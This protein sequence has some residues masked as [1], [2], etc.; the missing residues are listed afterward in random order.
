LIAS[1]K[2]DPE[3][4]PTQRSDEMASEFPGC[5]ASVHNQNP[6]AVVCSDQ[7]CDKF[8]ESDTFH[9]KCADFGK[10]NTLYPISTAECFDQNTGAT[11]E[12]TFVQTKFGLLPNCTPPLLT[13]TCFCCCSCLAFGTPIATPD[14]A[15]AIELFNI[16]DSVSVGSWDKSKL[17]WAN[18]LVQFSS[19]TDPGSINTMIFIQFG[20]GRKI[21]AT[22]DNLFLMSDGKL[23]RADR[24]V[25]GKDQI[26]TADGSALGVSAVLSGQWTKGLHHIATGLEFTG[27]LDGHLIN[28]NGIVTGDYCLQINQHE[29]I[30]RGLMDDPADTPALGSSK[31]AEMHGHLQTGRTFAKGSGEVNVPAG[32]KPF[33]LIDN[34][35][36]PD[37]AAKLFTDAQAQ[38]IVDNHDSTFRAV[39]D[40]S[41]FESM[42]YLIRLFKGFYPDINI[43]IDKTNPQFNTFAFEMY[44]KKHLVISGEILRM[45]GLFQE[46]YQFILAQ[47]IARLLGQKP[48]AENGFSYVAA[49]D[50]YATSSVLRTVNYL[51]APDFYNK[52]L[53][54]VMLLF[55][56]I[57]DG[58][59]GG[60]PDDLANDP[61]VGCRVVSL[62]TGI[63]G[64]DVSPCACN[65]LALL[66]AFSD[67]AEPDNLLLQLIFDEP[68]D[69]A[70]VTDLYNFKFASKDT[71]AGLPT[72]QSASVSPQN[73]QE[74][75]LQ[76]QSPLDRE[77]T[78]TVEDIVSAG[79][80]V[81]GDKTSATFSFS[82]KTPSKPK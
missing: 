2:E 14:G 73:S 75:V 22:P 62:N 29:L 47:G 81:L 58:N 63:F 21:I 64:G 50:F 23:K 44:G 25:P 3:S 15:K 24:L 6:T 72:V 36:I 48:V 71:L 34:A 65:D 13:V 10:G 8:S 51:T 20:D 9:S 12:P 32:F 60:N 40:D 61:P 7:H 42:S 74:V 56:R 26:L 5:E 30:K 52:L 53:Q 70:S 17:G 66:S 18:G 54:Q 68:V 46:A 31:F 19:G 67:S 49:A 77:F 28:A 43:S 80:S 57:S 4:T 76:V 78:V 59:A 39:Y 35:L 79:G 16:G 33:T 69:P 37:N 41:G 27:S 11:S 55:N 45:D 38:D 82:S 1:V